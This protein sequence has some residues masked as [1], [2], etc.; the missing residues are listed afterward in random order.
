M[1]ENYRTPWSRSGRRAEIRPSCTKSR[2]HNHCDKTA[3]CSECCGQTERDGLRETGTSTSC[4]MNETHCNDLSG[5]DH[6]KISKQTQR[7]LLHEIFSLYRSATIYCIRTAI[8]FVISEYFCGFRNHHQSKRRH[9]CLNAKTKRHL[10]V[11][12]MFRH[13]TGWRYEVSYKL[14]SSNLQRKNL[15]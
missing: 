12:G 5:M 13:G 6:S 14:R 2:C 8:Y 1:E 11:R 15:G 3:G 7:L 10:G 9:S 4:N